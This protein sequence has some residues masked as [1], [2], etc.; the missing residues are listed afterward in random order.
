MMGQKVMDFTVHAKT[1]STVLQLI[2]VCKKQKNE[3]KT[4]NRRFVIRGLSIIMI[5]FRP[6]LN[7]TKD[8]LKDENS[9]PQS[10]TDLFI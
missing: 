9:N 6:Y 8:S 5:F 10:R 1:V 3:Q 2:M 7:I 4:P